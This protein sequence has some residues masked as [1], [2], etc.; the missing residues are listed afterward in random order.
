MTR[1]RPSD[2]VDQRRNS[3][4]L[5]FPNHSFMLGTKGDVETFFLLLNDLISE[6]VLEDCYPTIS[7]DLYRTLVNGYNLERFKKEASELK[8]AFSALSSD[9]VAWDRYPF[10]REEG[11]FDYQHRRI[12]PAKPTLLDVFEK[13]FAGF[14]KAP[15]WVEKYL[16]KGMKDFPRIVVSPT[17][18]R[19]DRKFRKFTD[20]EFLEASA[21]PLW[22]REPA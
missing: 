2:L 3:F 10:N 11:A 9:R 6:G 16:A 13:F 4:G 22:L 5:V 19:T 12:D 17:E 20:A 15:F 18:I 14:E 7:H 8:E 1:N 21:D